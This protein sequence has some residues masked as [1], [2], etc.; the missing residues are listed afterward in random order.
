MDAIAPPSFI[1]TM[2]IINFQDKK[3]VVKLK[4]KDEG[5]SANRLEWF[6]WYSNSDLVLKKDG[7]L[8]FCEEMVD[9]QFEDIK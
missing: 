8:F 9:V 4:V 6:K 5:V 3:C 7:T 1:K 2:E